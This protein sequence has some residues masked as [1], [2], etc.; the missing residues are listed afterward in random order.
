M[1]SAQS[2]QSP[3]RV[4]AALIL[5]LALAIVAVPVAAQ[6]SISKPSWAGPK[7]CRSRATQ[8]EVR[9]ESPD[10]SH[11]QQCLGAARRVH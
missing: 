11:V 3:I 4:L 5:L 8:K 6:T 2:I 9:F 7:Q 10:R 1:H